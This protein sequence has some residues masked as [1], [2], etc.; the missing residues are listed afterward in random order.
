MEKKQFPPVRVIENAGFRTTVPTVAGGDVLAGPIPGPWIERA[1]ALPGKALSLAIVIWFQAGREG[2]MT[3][4]FDQ[5]LLKR[6]NISRHSFYRSLAALEA[7]GLVSV[8]R[9]PNTTPKVAINSR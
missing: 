6:F 2:R 8:R 7:A 1:A 4:D 3:V 9:S 5:R